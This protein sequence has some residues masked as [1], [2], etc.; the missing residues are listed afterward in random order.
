MSDVASSNRDHADRL[1]D[2]LRCPETRSRLVRD[3]DRLV[4]TDASRRLAYPI[5]DGF[6]VMLV[7]EAMELSDEEWRG[8]IERSDS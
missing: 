2:Q 7:S 8:V 6:P 1:L 5:R 4:S 3:G